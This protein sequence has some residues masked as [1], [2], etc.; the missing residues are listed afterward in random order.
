M[1]ARE[2]IATREY[3]PVDL[4]RQPPERPPSV[5]ELLEKRRKLLAP[6]WLLDFGT[7]PEVDVYNSSA[8]IRVDDGKPVVIVRE[9]EGDQFSSQNRF[10]RYDSGAKFRREPNFSNLS[11]LSLGWICQDPAT[12]YVQGNWVI[13]QVEVDPKRLNAN[14]GDTCYRSA[15]YAGK[16]LDS[17]SLI[18]RSPDMMKGVRLVELKDGRVGV[19]T[20]PQQPL[21]PARGGLGKIGFTAVGALE[22]INIGVLAGAPLIPDLYY[23]QDEEWRGVNDVSLLPNGELAVLAHQARFEKNHAKWS[24]GYY[25]LFFTFNPES[26]RVDHQQILA[27][28]DDFHF[29][30]QV[31]AKSPELDNVLYP[32]TLL[33]PNGDIRSSYAELMGGAKDSRMAAGYIPNPLAEWLDAHP[34]YRYRVQPF[35]RSALRQRAAA[36]NIAA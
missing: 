22:Q 25:P 36:R 19:F 15:I 10:F 21:D 13:T 24:K 14:A 6:G 18:S 33:F 26:Y 30:G 23:E 27:T 1:P 35:D 9:E 8:P 16:E 20:R 29:N 17:L 12:A 5:S 31:K 4:E 3:Q 32:S 11:E 34:Q 2:T 28:L 7:P